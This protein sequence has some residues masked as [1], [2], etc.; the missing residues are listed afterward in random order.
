MSARAFL[1]TAHRWIGLA[2][3]LP[4][5]VLAGT[6]FAMLA[7]HATGFGGTQRLDHAIAGTA[8]LDRA[9]AEARTALPGAM[10]GLI[11]PGIDARHAWAA[12]MH[13]PDGHAPVAEIDPARG[14]LLAIRSAGSGIEET[15]LA[16]H[17]SLALGRAGRIVIL[18]TAVGLV[19]LSISGFVIM[20]RRWRTL[21]TSPLKGAMKLRAL[22]HWTGLVGIAFLLL[23]ATTGFLLLTMKG[24]GGDRKHA[25]APPAT[26]CASAPIAPMLAAVLRQNPRSEIQGIMPGVGG[27]PVVIMVLSR[28]AAPWAKSWTLM[29]DSCSGVILP[30]RPTPAFMRFMIA[31]KSLHTGLWS[32]GPTLFL[33]LIAA[34]L[35]LILV[36]TGP[37]L[38]LRRHMPRRAKAVRS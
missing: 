34:L 9:L 29:F 2:C 14:H 23:W 12:Q 26:R 22:H 37:W 7:C 24:G 17:N 10:P 36:I 11:L 18:A 19:V 35:P 15:L 4:F 20:R 28:D 32:R 38:W 6:G 1:W 33:Y 3:T 16:V 13:M 21:R 27:K 5:L 8:G 30:A 31:A 25:G